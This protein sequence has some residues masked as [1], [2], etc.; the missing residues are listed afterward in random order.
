MAAFPPWVAWR[1]IAEAPVNV[2]RDN[3]SRVLQK[4]LCIVCYKTCKLRME[5]KCVIHVHSETTKDI[6]FKSTLRM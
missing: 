5:G 3:V 4:C 2:C 1:R 6:I